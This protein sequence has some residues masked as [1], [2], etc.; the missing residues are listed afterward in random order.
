[1]FTKQLFLLR[2][3]RNVAS[4]CVERNV[5]QTFRHAVWRVLEHL[6]Y[7]RWVATHCQV[8]ECTLSNGA[9]YMRGFANTSDGSQRCTN[10]IM[11]IMETSKGT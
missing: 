10:M 7:Q 9:A 8:L 11:I 1:M 3:E 5:A 2:C 4:C 6:L